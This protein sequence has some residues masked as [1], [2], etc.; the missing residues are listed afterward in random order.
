MRTVSAAFVKWIPLA[1]G[2][3]MLSL[4]SYATVQQVYRQGAN[5]PQIQMAEDIAAQVGQGAGLDSLVGH[6]AVDPSKSL[7]PFVIVFDDKGAVKASGVVLGGKTPTPPAGVLEVAKAKGENRV[8]W[9]PRADARIAAVIVPVAGGPGGY[10]L[11]GRSLRTA[12]ERVDGLGL[13]VLLGWAATMVGTLLAFVAVRW[14][15]VRGATTE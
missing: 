6:D 7:A 1:V 14:L 5:D 12:E 8:T 10:V 3:T 15:K 13:M 4:V 11:A 9:Q 2:V